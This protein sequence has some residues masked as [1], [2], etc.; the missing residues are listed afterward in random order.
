VIWANE[1][2]GRY[3]GFGWRR[4]KSAGLSLIEFAAVLFTFAIV[5]LFFKGLH[6]YSGIS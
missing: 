3:W 2:W 1:P 4:T 6:A 5:N